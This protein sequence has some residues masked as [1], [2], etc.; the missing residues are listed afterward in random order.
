MRGKRR[1]DVLPFLF[2]ADEV[3]S[4][5]ELDTTVSIGLT[6][7]RDETFGNRK[8]QMIPGV[9]VR[10]ERYSRLAD[11]G[12]SAYADFGGLQDNGFHG[13]PRRDSGWAFIHDNIRGIDRCSAERPE[14]RSSDA[15]EKDVN[16]LRNL[17]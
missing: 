8:G 13:Q 7:P 4:A 12:D 11:D 2:H 15:A 6:K 14:E 17:M 5:V 16:F 10:I 1:H 9:E 3:F